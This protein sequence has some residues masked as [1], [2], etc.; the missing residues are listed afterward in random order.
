MTIKVSTINTA[1]GT[2][3]PLRC[4]FFA[5]GARLRRLTLSSVPAK[6]LQTLTAYVF[7]SSLDSIVAHFIPAPDIALLV[8]GLRWTLPPLHCKANK[9]FAVGARHPYKRRVYR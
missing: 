1:T 8:G 4:V 6:P 7:T 3:T 2:H 9:N 5:N